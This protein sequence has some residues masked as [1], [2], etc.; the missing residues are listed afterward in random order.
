MLPG[1]ETLDV[2][3]AGAVAKRIR[4]AVSAKQH[5]LE[6]VLCPL[7]AEVPH[8]CFQCS[9]SLS[10]SRF[11]WKGL[12]TSSPCRHS[13]ADGWGLQQTSRAQACAACCWM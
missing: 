6:D 12:I 1:S 9:C 2:R 8:F 13:A 5:G 10:V 3:D 4:G 7:I 11:Q